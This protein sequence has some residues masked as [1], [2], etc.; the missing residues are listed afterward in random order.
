MQV[1]F[2]NPILIFI[3]SFALLLIGCAT[4]I[5]WPKTPLIAFRMVFV[6]GAL[7]I[8]HDLLMTLLW[9][10]ATAIWMRNRNGR[11]DSK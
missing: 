6:G 9:F 2:G 7:M 4:G 1:R 11:D 5:R 3:Y 10:S 8:I